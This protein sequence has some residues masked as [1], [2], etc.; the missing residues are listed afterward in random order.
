MHKFSEIYYFIE[1]FNKQ[2]IEKLNKNISLIYRN[3]KKNYNF[4]EIEDLRKLCANQKRKF[5]IANEI[6]LA[7]RLGTDGVYIPSFNKLCNF[8]NLNAKKGFK[9][10][11]S[12]HNIIELK[13]KENQGCKEIAIAPIFKTKKNDYFLGVIKF[14]LIAKNTK[15]IIAL[16]GINETNISRVK[17]TKSTA[18]A[19]ISWIKKNGPSKLGPF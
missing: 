1:E 16:G 18:I 19:S 13:N 9:I 3:Y 4:Q 8:K 14:N 7:L 6:K 10:F 12:A 15:R 11:G 2:Q 17:L 5:Y